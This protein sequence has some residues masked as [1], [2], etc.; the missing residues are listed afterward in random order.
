MLL[1][2]SMLGR[3][4]GDSKDEVRRILDN[5]P[6]KNVKV[7]GRGTIYL[8]PQEV[9]ETPGFKKTSERVRKI[10][11]RQQANLRRKKA[12]LVTN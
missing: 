2:L 12:E 7:V 3:D 5:T 9:I 4:H 8:D 11:A 1:L 10:R 6:Y